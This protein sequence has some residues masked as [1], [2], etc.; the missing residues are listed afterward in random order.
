[1]SKN[2]V[3]PDIRKKSFTLYDARK[4]LLW[5]L[6]AGIISCGLVNLLVGGRPWFLYVLGAEVIFFIIFVYHPLVDHS[7]MQKFSLATLVI[8]AYLLMIDYLNGNLG[9][10]SLVVPIV[11]FS[12]LIVLGVM[13]FFYFQKQKQN[14]ISVYSLMVGSMIT[15]IM[16]IFGL[17][18]I[19]WSLIVLGSVALTLFILSIILYLKPLKRELKKKFHV[20]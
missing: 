9:W 18:K 3:Y 12:S 16:G 4:I 6:I 15:V 10:S 2:S 13:F 8:C 14:L 17:L 20:N 7:F 19:N 11:C 1:M 5:I